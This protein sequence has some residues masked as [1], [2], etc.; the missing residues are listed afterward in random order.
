V[1]VANGKILLVLRDHPPE[2]GRWS[3]PGGRLERG[4][5]IAQA[6]VRELSEETGLTGKCGELIGWVER[7]GSSYHYVILD[8]AVELDPGPQPRAGGDARD[9]RWYP[10]EQLESL[11]LVGGLYQFFLDHGVLPP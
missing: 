1:A 6:V 4:E 5:T 10:L 7:I 8:F 3:V 9:A 11:D 2:A